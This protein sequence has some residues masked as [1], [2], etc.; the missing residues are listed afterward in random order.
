MNRFPTSSWRLSLLTTMAVIVAIW[1][2][3][4]PP[5]LSGGSFPT[6]AYAASV[7]QTGAGSTDHHR[8]HHTRHHRATA[9]SVSNTHETAT[10]NTSTRNRPNANRRNPNRNRRATLNPQPLPP[11]LAN[12]NTANLNARTKL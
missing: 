11:R 3:I 7:A 1:S 6:T 12:R 2:F 5:E 10:G 8:R 4:A 9:K